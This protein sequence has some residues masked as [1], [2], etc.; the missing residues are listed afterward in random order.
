MNSGLRSFDATRPPRPFLCDGNGY[1]RKGLKQASEHVQTLRAVEYCNVV[2]VPPVI[3]TN[4]VVLHAWRELKKNVANQVRWMHIPA[5]FLYI[6]N[7]YHTN[8]Y[9]CRK[10]NNPKVL[11]CTT[12]TFLPTQGD[13]HHCQCHLTLLL[14]WGD[15]DTALP[16]RL[17]LWGWDPSPLHMLPG[18]VRKCS[19]IVAI[20]RQGRTK[21]AILIT[22]YH[23]EASCSYW[24]PLDLH[25]G[26]S[27]YGSCGHYGID[28]KNKK[29][30]KKGWILMNT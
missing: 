8:M 30:Q 24:Q 26:F 21:G 4:P 18:L 14:P 27:S 22:T 6:L 2:V 12:S 15:Q 29:W 28:S 16:Q 23:K 9:Q 11:L 1:P 20:V 5:R 17:R 13:P 25:F 10:G 3:D 19:P 7:I